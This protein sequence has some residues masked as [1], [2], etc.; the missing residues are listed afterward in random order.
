[1]ERILNILTRCLIISKT[2]P[3]EQ[4]SQVSVV[5]VTILIVGYVVFNPGCAP[6]DDAYYDIADLVIV[7]EYFCHD[8]INPPLNDFVYTYLSDEVSERGLTLM[9]PESLN[10]SPSSKFGLMVHDFLPEENHENKIVKLKEMVF[11]LVQIKHVH[12]IFITDLEIRKVDVY[13]NW[14]HIWHDFVG[15]VAQ[16]NSSINGNHSIE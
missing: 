10:D 2:S 3:G 1:M 4:E 12:A 11:D 13:A 6:R 9:I 16:A 5:F 15:F 8:F 7:F 14:G